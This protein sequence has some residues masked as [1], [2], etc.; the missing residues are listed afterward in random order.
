MSL[1]AC[2]Y[3]ANHKMKSSRLLIHEDQCPDRKSKVLK[4]CPFNPVHK[5]APESFEKHKRECPHRPVIDTELEQELK[6]YLKTQG[7]KVLGATKAETNS[8]SKTQQEKNSENVN[9]NL[10]FSKSENKTKVENMSLSRGDNKTKSEQKVIGL[11][12]ND[13]SLKKERKNKQKE[14]MN[15]IENAEFEESGILDTNL[16][17]KMYVKNV[18]EIDALWENQFEI[19]RVEKEKLPTSNQTNQMN[20]GINN[21]RILNLLESMTE[22][23]EYDPNASDIFIDS[24]NKNT[25]PKNMIYDPRLQNLENSFSFLNESNK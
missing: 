20:N 9:E 13:K 14:M 6:E 16:S 15:L 18:E 2:R 4:I 23:N 5:L 21:S 7:S 3:N 8:I 24:K 25:I 10:N 19:S 12:A 22:N 1:V 11:K 17:Q